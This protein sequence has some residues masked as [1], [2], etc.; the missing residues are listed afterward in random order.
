M[1]S[2]DVVGEPH[3][4]SEIVLV[5]REGHRR[6]ISGI[7]GELHPVGLGLCRLRELLILPANA[8]IQRQLIG[9]TPVV[10]DEPV[11]VGRRERNVSRETRAAQVERLV[12]A[13]VVTQVRAG[14]GDERRA[15][16]RADGAVRG[17]RV[18]V[19]VG[20]DAGTLKQIDQIFLDVIDVDAR[21]ARCARPRTSVTLSMN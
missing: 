20:V 7:A 19:R 21:L 3:T 9:Q 13:R 17:N 10:L 1:R 6:R 12:V 15:A 16:G 11:V 14:A 8:K 2:V 4:R 5:L 18:D